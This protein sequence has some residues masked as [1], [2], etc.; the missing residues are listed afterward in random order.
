MRFN[1]LRY[2]YWYRIFDLGAVFISLCLLSLTTLSSRSPCPISFVS[3]TPAFTCPPL[4]PRPAL[5][6]TTHTRDLQAIRT[7]ECSNYSAPCPHPTPFPL[8]VHTRCTQY[9]RYSFDFVLLQVR[10]A[11][12]PPGTDQPPIIPPR[13]EATKKDVAG[14]GQTKTPLKPPVQASML[15]KYPVE[16]PVLIKYPVQASVLIRYPVQAIVLT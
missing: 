6:S 3:L 7:S 15:M 1:S 8:Y 16:A 11:P 13:P 12:Q 2:M 9:L 10:T 4:P 5:S 14:A